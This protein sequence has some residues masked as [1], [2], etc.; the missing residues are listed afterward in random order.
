MHFALNRSYERPRAGRGVWLWRACAAVLIPALVFAIGCSSPSARF[1]YVATGQGIYA[2]RID[3]RTGGASQIFGSPFVAKTSPTNAASASSVVVHPSNNFLYAANQDTSTISRFNIDPTTGALTEVLP[4][5]ALVTP[6]GAVGLSPAFLVMDNAGTFL[7]VGNQITN[8]VW[9]FSI[10]ASGALTF[11]SSTQLA[12]S[13]SGLTLASSGNFLYVPV[14]TFSAIYAFSVSAGALT[15][16]GPPTVVNGGV[17]RLGIDPNA[18]F[19]YVPNPS[20]NTVTVL[21]IQADGTLLAKPGAFATANAPVAAVTNPTGAFVYVANFGSA[22]L[23][24]FQVDT[25]TGALTALTTS[26]VSTGTQPTSFASDP[27][28]KFFFVVNQGSN[29][30]TEFTLNTN[31]TLVSTGNAVQ[32][33]VLPRS[34]SI[35]R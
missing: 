15:Q 32:V 26:T 33:S 12:A 1:G 29:S 13:A 25:T 9:V 30:V 3:A 23:S 17:G 19:L 5:T 27:T 20:N 10:G 31:G 22:N 8:D 7:F 4:R 28:A 34:F 35:T 18:H 21:L 2:F 16:V 6:S 24:Q 14:D 11:V